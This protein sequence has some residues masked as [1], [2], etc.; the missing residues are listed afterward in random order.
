MLAL[1]AVV[2]GAVVEQ[3]RLGPQRQARVVVSGTLLAGGCWLYSRVGTVIWWPAP[4]YPA[5]DQVLPLPGGLHATV[6]PAG[7]EDCGSASCTETM[8][9]GNRDGLQDLRAIG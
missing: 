9:S 6:Q 4:F 2:C 3:V 1:S 8:L 5:T 7:A